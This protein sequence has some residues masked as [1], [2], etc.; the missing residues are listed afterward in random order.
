MKIKGLIFCLLIVGI[1]CSKEF[2]TLFI[3][4]EN[5]DSNNRIYKPG[6]VFIYDYE[7]IQDER[8]L[9]LEKNEGMF[10]LSEFKLV[11]PTSDEIKVD[12]IHMIV[13]PVSG[14][15]RTNKN[16]TQIAYLQDPI[17]S[18]MSF[19]GVVENEINVWIHPVRKGFFN[20]LEIAPF[21]FIKYPSVIGK[22]WNDQMKIGQNWSNEI[23]GFWQGDLLLRY[24]YE[25]VG[26]ESL[27][28]KMGEIECYV[29]NS[30]AQSDIGVTNLKSFFSETFGFVRLEYQLLNGLKVNMWLDD[31][32]TGKEFNDV[33]TFLKTKKYLK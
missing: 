2:A 6:N 27:S 5:I 16:Q 7:I 31:Y 30:S 24:H 4:K 3:E 32:M 26:K 21:P 23:W 11:P 18:S 25:I 9:K 15:D 22:K 1:S 33:E 28:T 19:T 14:S 10:A 29:V 13:L 17:F 8:K 20:S 12:K